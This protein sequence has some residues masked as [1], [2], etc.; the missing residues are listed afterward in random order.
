MTISLTECAAPIRRLRD[1]VVRLEDVARPL[2]LPGLDGREWYEL[3]TGKLVPQLT[4]DA[5]LIVAVVGG[6]NI[7]KTVVF[8]HIAGSRASSTSPLAS[9]TK[10][11]TCLIPAG[12]AESHDLS[13]LFPGFTPAPSTSPE[14][15]LQESDTN[16]LYWREEPSLPENLLVLDTPDIDSE[17]RINWERADGIRRSADVLIAL[18]TQQKYNDAAVKEFFRKAAAEDKAVMIVFNQVQL[19][20]DEE[21]W[22]LWIGTFCDETG[23]NPEHVYLAPYDRRAAE[24]NELPFFEREWPIA[25]RDAGCEMRDPAE[26]VPG[27]E[28]GRQTA[29]HGRYVDD[30]VPQSQHQPGGSHP[31]SHI[32]QPASRTPHPA[33]RIP[34]PETRRSLLHGLVAASVRGNQTANIAGI[35]RLSD[36]HGGG[37]AVVSPRD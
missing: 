32:P 1:A 26:G 33:T 20:E 6:T 7:G 25:M 31:E 3:L 17:V 9:G 15:A 2:E 21:Y 4:D 28:Y 23:V 30:C 37:R 36:R 13:E 27:I 19:P 11:P 24:G 16:W 29:R 5:F 18:L 10:H 34:H 8:N 35:N 22:P 12:F 14:Q